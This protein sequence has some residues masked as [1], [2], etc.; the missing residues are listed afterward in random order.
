[1]VKQQIPHPDN[2]STT[3]HKQLTTQQQTHHP[4]LVEEKPF[5][6]YPLPFTLHPS[7]FTLYPS[8]FTYTIKP[9]TLHPN[10]LQ[11]NSLH[12]EKQIEPLVRG[13]TI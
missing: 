9:F 1:M 3:N 4:Q 2:K 11:L 10:S 6:L 12:K 7:P 8:P 5:T 13:V